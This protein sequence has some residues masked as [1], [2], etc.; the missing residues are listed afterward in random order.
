MEK[1]RK[2][3]PRADIGSIVLQPTPRAIL[4][5]TLPAR[6]SDG[7]GGGAARRPSSRAATPTYTHSTTTVSTPGTPRSLSAQST[8][9]RRLSMGD[10]SLRPPFSFLPDEEGGAAAA[11][12]VRTGGSTVTMTAATLATAGTGGEVAPAELEAEEARRS[13]RNGRAAQPAGVGGRPSEGGR[14]REPADADLQAGHGV[15]SGGDGGDGIGAPLPPPP[16]PSPAVAEPGAC[17]REDEDVD[18]GTR[19]KRRSLMGRMLESGM[20]ERQREWAKAR[21]RKVGRMTRAGF[22]RRERKCKAST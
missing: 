3:N 11:L 14:G 13:A 4:P 6:T 2:I 1:I 5:A 15:A 22:G 7:G 10:P 17:V 16:A 8:S 9:T 21:N 18:G 19:S 12:A 20:L